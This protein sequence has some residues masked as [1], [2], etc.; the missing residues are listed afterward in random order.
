LVKPPGVGQPFGIDGVVTLEDV[1]A[2]VF[3]ACEGADMARL[4][5]RADLHEEMGLEALIR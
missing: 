5:N 1:C 3:L 4:S 2:N